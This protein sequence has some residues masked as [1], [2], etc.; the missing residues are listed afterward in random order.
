MY[1]NYLSIYLRTYLFLS[2]FDSYYEEKFYNWMVDYDV[3]PDSGNHFTHMLEAFAMNDD[4]IETHNAMGNS[5]FTL[6][7]NAY[8]H[9]TLGEWREY[10]RFGVM[11][12]PEE[13]PEGFMG[14]H[15]G[16]GDIL[17]ASVDW[18]KAGAVTPVKNQGQ[19]G[20]C[21]SFS[22]TG[23]L[24]GGMKIHHGTLQ[25]LS[26]EMLVDCDHLSNGCNGGS[27]EN[28]FT[29]VKQVGGL[30]TEAA[31]P[32]T[33]GVRKTAGTCQ[34]TCQKVAA[35]APQGWFGVGKDDY[36]MMSAITGQ[37][38]SISIDASSQYFMHYRSGVLTAPCGTNLDHGVLA[39][40]K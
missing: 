32:Y 11:K 36:G 38:V 28:A 35:S 40:G 21:W 31:Y 4:F 5:T 13:N 14:T 30:C 9:M 1:A 20:S 25:S 19:C 33:A 18:V 26:E 24:E 12:K 3:K 37:P 29:W 15:K 6:G 27:M 10:M 2:R 7:H 22:T 17:P 8:S 23:A 16:V 39:V 34:T